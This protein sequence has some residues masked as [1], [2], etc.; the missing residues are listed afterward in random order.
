MF[1]GALPVRAEALAGFLAV[2][3]GARAPAPTTFLAAFVG[4]FTAPA[5]MRVTPTTVRAAATFRRPGV[6]E[7][8]ISTDGDEVSQAGFFS[9]CTPVRRGR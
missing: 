9:S 3:A 4:V 8:A 7:G 6:A 2:V 1:A 5:V